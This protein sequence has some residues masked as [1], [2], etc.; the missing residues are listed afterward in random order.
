MLFSEMC[1]TV[2]STGYRVLATTIAAEAGIDGQQFVTRP[3]GKRFLPRLQE[4]VRAHGQ[5]GVALSFAGVQMMDASFADEVFASF[6]ADRSRRIEMIGCLLLTDL[7]PTSRDNLELA[8]MSR[9]E[10]E[11]GLRNCV[12]PIVVKQGEIELVGKAEDHVRKTFALLCRRGQLTARQL[13]SE[14]A[15][16]IGAASTR[17]KVL[18]N[19]GLACRKEERDERG[20][21]YIYLSL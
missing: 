18:F 8:V 14:S 13:A 7:D 19:L 3:L 16:G 11:P 17:L 4:T 20:R 21:L 9:P 1:G 5:S 6:A 10:R 2:L 15:L 12:L